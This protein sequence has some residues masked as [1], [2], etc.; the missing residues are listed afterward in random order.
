MA[1]PPHGAAVGTNGS[2]SA[3]GGGNLADQVVASA[4]RYRTH[5]PL[6][7]SLLKE[8]GLERSHHRRPHPV[9]SRTR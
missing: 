6:V 4:L 8:I 1:K 3:N 5:A 2:G 9:P 7:D